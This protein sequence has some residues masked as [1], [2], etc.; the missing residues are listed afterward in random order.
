MIGLSAKNNTCALFLKKK[1]DTEPVACYKLHKLKERNPAQEVGGG[2]QND[3]IYADYDGNRFD[4]CRSDH[5]GSPGCR[6][7]HETQKRDF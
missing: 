4:L 1:L 6:S 3:G 2:N 5:P 7:P